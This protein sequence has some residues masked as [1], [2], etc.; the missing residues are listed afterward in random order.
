MLPFSIPCD[1]CLEPVDTRVDY[2]VDEVVDF[3]D[4]ASDGR[5]KRRK[6]TILMDTTSTWTS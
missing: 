6:K 1:R 4:N 3:N 2:T 5:S